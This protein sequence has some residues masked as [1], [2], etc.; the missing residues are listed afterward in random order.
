MLIL[1]FSF[2]SY[3]EDE[4]NR[5]IQSLKPTEQLAQYTNTCSTSTIGTQEKYV[6]GQQWRH[7]NDVIDVVP[8]SW[9]LNL[10]IFPGTDIINSLHE[11]VFTV[12]NPS[13]LTI[14]SPFSLV[15]RDKVNPVGYVSCVV[16]QTFNFSFVSVLKDA[17]VNL[18]VR[19]FSLWSVKGVD[20]LWFWIAFFR[21]KLK[22]HKLQLW[23]W[24]KRL[25]TMHRIV[26][27][28]MSP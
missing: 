3:Y 12:N 14:S 2:I 19:G 8:V 22:G 10:N 17:L 6:Q 26:I 4:W 18:H 23:I 25:S 21:L 27:T 7:Q 15:T 24:K 28:S 5:I 1:L 13:G 16:Y 11:A 9:L 20:E